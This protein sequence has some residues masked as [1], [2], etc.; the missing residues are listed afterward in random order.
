V[1]TL[2]A[3]LAL[4]PVPASAGAGRRAVSE[5]LTDWGVPPD[6][7]GD[8][9]LVVSEL[10]TNAVLHAPADDPL[11]LDLS[12]NDRVLRVA[13]SDSSSAAP[14]RRSPSG[15]DEGGRGIGILDTLA[16]RWG[17]IARRGGKALWFEIDLLT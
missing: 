7:V 13:L 10:V 9:V 11:T 2:R 15:H 1:T 17:V 8:A 3:R 5:V 6:T 12:V 16:S 4:L 14:R